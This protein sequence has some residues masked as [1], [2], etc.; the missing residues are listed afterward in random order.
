MFHIYFL[1]AM[2]LERAKVHAHSHA[3]VVI[4]YARV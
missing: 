4:N 2:L 3:K 1:C